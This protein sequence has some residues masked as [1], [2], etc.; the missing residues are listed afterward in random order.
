MRLA[1]EDLIKITL[2]LYA[3]DAEEMK[4]LYGWGWSEK[5]R[6]LIRRHLEDRKSNQ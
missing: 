2:N 4:R 6:Q 5:V 1:G 3:K